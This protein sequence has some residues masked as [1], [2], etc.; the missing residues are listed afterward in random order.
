M[1]IWRIGIIIC[2]L[3]FRLL[4]QTSAGVAGRFEAGGAVDLGVGEQRNR[5]L[6]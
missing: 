6:A 4:G 5:K 2:T 1:N 3:M